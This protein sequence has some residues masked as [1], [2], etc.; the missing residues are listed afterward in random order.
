MIL[1]LEREVVSG[2]VLEPGIVLRTLGTGVQSDSLSRQLPSAQRT[3]VGQIAEWLTL[4][5]TLLLPRGEVADTRQLSGR[6]HPLQDLSHCDEVDVVPIEHFVDPLDKSI[7]VLWIQLQPTC[8]EE[9]TQRR[10]IG[11]IV[12]VEVMVEEVVEL[13]TSDNVGTAVNH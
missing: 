8:V 9:D 1:F 4:D 12:A 13:V 10:P 5:K 6:L 11:L 2:R 3:M 7:K